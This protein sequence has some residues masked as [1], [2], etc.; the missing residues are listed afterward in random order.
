MYNCNHSV[1]TIYIYIINCLR[2]Q[3][4]G[5]YPAFFL[6]FTLIVLHKLYYY[7]MYEQYIAIHNLIG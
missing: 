6:K 7:K 4:R 1:I 3:Q 5:Y 2:H